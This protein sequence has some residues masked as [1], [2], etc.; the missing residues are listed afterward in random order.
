VRILNVLEESF[1]LAFHEL[2]HNRLRALLSLLGITIGIFCIIAVFSAVDSLQQDVQGSVKSLGEDAVYV[3]KW[4]WNFSDENYEWWEYMKRPE[5]NYADYRAI[6]DGADKTSAVVVQAFL[7]GKTVKRGGNSVEQVNVTGVTH[8]FDKIY[9]IELD[10]GRYFSQRESQA[11]DNVVI[12]GAN[13]ADGLSAGGRRLMGEDIKVMGQ[14]LR[15]IGIRSREGQGLINFGF[16]DGIMVP[17]RF[18]MRLVNVNSTTLPQN[19]IAS[20]APG[21]SLDELKSQLRGIMRVQRRLRPS[22][23]DDFALNQM[24]VL[25]DQFAPMFA[26]I[27]FAGAFI[28]IFSI[29]VGG[30][31]IANIMFVSV[32][33]R[34]SIIGIKKAL[35][36][37][38]A[39]VLSEF[40]IE[41]VILCTV[42]GVLG[43]VGVW[44]LMQVVNASPD[45][46][47]NFVLTA[48]NIA[49]GMIISISIGMLAGLAPA[50]WAA[51][52]N[53]VEAMR[54]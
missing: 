27:R 22:Q 20:T 26:V 1:N 15:V 43:L 35:G 34:T 52:M 12:V 16:D 9:G 32:K 25:N 37:R 23:E 24:S 19:I 33:E 41:A 17:Y 31:G 11:G 38:S 8:D 46:G 18:L 44:L 13:V 2:I 14:K 30:F 40:L 45:I 47:M 54:S 39:Y 7:D 50:L 3:Q 6:R 36:A 51:R 10:E 53:P 4:P 29:L 28:G 49:I 42:G 48:K 5:A 21:V